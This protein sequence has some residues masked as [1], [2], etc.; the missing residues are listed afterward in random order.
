MSC[1]ISKELA[2]QEI[3]KIS[4]KHGDVME[5]MTAAYAIAALRGVDIVRCKECRYWSGTPHN[6]ICTKHDIL[7]VYADDYCSQGES[8]YAGILECPIWDCQNRDELGYCNT[9]EC[10]NPEH[11]VVAYNP[12]FSGDMRCTITYTVD[13]DK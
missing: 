3:A 7:E 6:P 1:Y 11:N 10:T 2:M 4:A 5:L 8:K 12:K 13:D 9:L